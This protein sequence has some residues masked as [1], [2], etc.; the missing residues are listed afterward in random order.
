MF[1][2]QAAIYGVTL[3][4][5]GVYTQLQLRVFQIYFSQELTSDINNWLT[6]TG[7]FILPSLL[8]HVVL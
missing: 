2:S 1:R 6:L 8:Y 5:V 7:M 3:R 4:F